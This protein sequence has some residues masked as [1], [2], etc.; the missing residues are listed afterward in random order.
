MVPSGE[1]SDGNVPFCGIAKI[2]TS[3][4]NSNIAIKDKSDLFSFL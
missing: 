3:V 1:I 2:R 4:K